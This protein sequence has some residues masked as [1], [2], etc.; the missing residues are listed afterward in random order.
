MGLLVRRVHSLVNRSTVRRL[1]SLTLRAIEVIGHS[2]FRQH[3]VLAYLDLPLVVV[4]TG[5]DVL[6]ADPAQQVVEARSQ[7]RSK[8]RTDPVY[9]MVSGKGAIDNIWA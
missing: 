5:V 9:P 3:R 4:L 7:Q 8:Q 1:V 2:I 6:P